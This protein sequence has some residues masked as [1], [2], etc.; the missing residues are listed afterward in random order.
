M[1]ATLVVIINK[2][3]KPNQAVL[4]PT[5][6]NQWFSTGDDFAP[7]PAPPPPGTFGIICRHL[8]VSRFG[9]KVLYLVESSQGYY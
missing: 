7:P 3:G 1:K 4:E 5:V 9:G 8:K 6:F 2:H